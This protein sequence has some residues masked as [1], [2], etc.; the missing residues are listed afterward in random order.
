MSMTM[1]VGS[2]TDR[3]VPIFQWGQ[4][5]HRGP[6]WGNNKRKTQRMWNHHLLELQQLCCTCVNHQR[7]AGGCWSLFQES[8]ARGRGTALTVQT[9][10]ERV[11]HS[12]SSISTSPNWRGAADCRSVRRQKWSII[13]I[14]LDSQFSHL[15]FY[16]LT[17]AITN[18]KENVNVYQRKEGDCGFISGLYFWTTAFPVCFSVLNIWTV[19]DFQFTCI[20]YINNP[21]KKRQSHISP[22]HDHDRLSC[23]QYWW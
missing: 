8:W 17:K 21:E 18:K 1:C 19:F 4:H 7:V 13:A 16:R 11:F 2:Q 5:W 10:Q 6:V 3:G 12:A 20:L 14:F 15:E 9:L 22:I 23:Q